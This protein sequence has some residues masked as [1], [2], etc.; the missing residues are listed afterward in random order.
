MRSSGGPKPPAAM[1]A[2]PPPQKA[3][4]STSAPSAACRSATSPSSPA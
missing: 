1:P 2:A 3:P 4:F